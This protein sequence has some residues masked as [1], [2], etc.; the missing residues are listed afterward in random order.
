MGLLQTS[1]GNYFCVGMLDALKEFVCVVGLIP[2]CLGFEGSLK[3]R[4]L[5]RRL[6]LLY[7]LVLILIDLVPAHTLIPL[8][9]LFGSLIVLAKPV[10]CL[11]FFDVFWSQ[12]S[13]GCTPSP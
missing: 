9:F 2:I 7:C 10:I 8:H 12:L 6:I 3:R 5:A 4:A 11:L 1:S 13:F